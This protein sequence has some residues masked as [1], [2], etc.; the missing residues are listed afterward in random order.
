MDF[1]DFR[2]ERG[3]FTIFLLEAH[4]G[5]VWL[6]YIN[7]AYPQGV[8]P[9][10]GDVYVDGSQLGTSV[11]A[12]EK[13]DI[14]D[15]EEYYNSCLQYIEDFEAS[16]RL[17][18]VEEDFAASYGRWPTLYQ[19]RYRV[20]DHLFFVIGN[21]IDWL[22]GVLYSDI[23]PV[24]YREM[25]L[26]EIYEYQREL[27]FE[28]ERK[29]SLRRQVQDLE[30]YATELNKIMTSLGLEMSEGMRGLL[31][32]PPDP[33]ELDLPLPLPEDAMVYLYPLS[34]RYSNIN[35]IP[36]DVHDDWLAL[37]WEAANLK[38]SRDCMGE[39]RRKARELLKSLTEQF[40]ARLENLVDLSMSLP[41]DEFE[42][43]ECW[44]P[45]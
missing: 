1:K 30:A 38:A 20:L 9:L 44:L 31:S 37:A 33:T 4:S 3:R 36:E 14:T 18:T 41:H 17:P 16:K 6:G 25:S 13:Y 23:F 10:S 11:M 43:Y 21:G 26:E 34:D 22:D 19:Y 24:P 28:E 7:I 5:G 42:D 45:E 12:Y 15:P 29:S 27:H 8:R 35:R 2:E 39:E 32:P 40:G